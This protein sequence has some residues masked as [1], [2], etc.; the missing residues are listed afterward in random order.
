MANTSSFV[1]FSA[2][3]IPYHICTAVLEQHGFNQM[4]VGPT[5]KPAQLTAILHDIYS[6]S[7]K[8][9]HFSQSINFN[10]DNCKAMLATFFWAVF[11]P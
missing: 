4:D 9:G 2:V 5:I 6:A 3:N 7:E 1:S 11:D 8:C 10:L